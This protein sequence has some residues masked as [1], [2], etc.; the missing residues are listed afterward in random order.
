MLVLTPVNMPRL[1]PEIGASP[2]GKG[3]VMEVIGINES[4]CSDVVCE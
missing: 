4:C 3:L 2:D 1:L